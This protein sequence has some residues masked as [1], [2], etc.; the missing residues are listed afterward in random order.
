[1]RLYRVIRGVVG[2]D[3]V[4]WM[5]VTCRPARP[6]GNVEFVPELSARRSLFDGDSWLEADVPLLPEGDR[7]FRWLCGF[8][9]T[10]T[11]VRSSAASTTANL[12]AASTVM[13]ENH[14]S[15]CNSCTRMKARVFS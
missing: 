9:L 8:G 15:S 4:T 7:V 13:I 10:P 1:M 11:P 2:N 5:Q 3:L 12:C 14:G 6:Q